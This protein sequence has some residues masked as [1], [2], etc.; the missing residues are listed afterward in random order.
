MKTNEE[1]IRKGHGHLSLSTLEHY[2]KVMEKYKSLRSSGKTHAES[3]DEIGVSDRHMH[4]IKE[5]LT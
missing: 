1:L 5:V 2:K 4:R 3:C